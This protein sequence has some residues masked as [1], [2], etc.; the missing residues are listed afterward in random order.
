MIN[1]LLPAELSFVSA[2][3]VRGTWNAPNWN[4]GTM[5]SGQVFNI[6][7]TAKVNEVSA[8]STVINTV[9]NTQDIAEAAVQLDDH[10]EP[11]NITNSSMEVTKTS[12]PATDGNY[13]TLGELIKYSII[14]KNTGDTVLNNITITD[15]KADAGSISPISVATLAVGA[16][17]TFT[18]THKITQANIDAGKVT[19]QATAKATLSN[20]FEISDIS[21]DPDDLSS[22]SDDPTITPIV[23]T[24]KLLLEKIADPADDG[25]YDSLGEIINYELYVKNTGNVTLNNIV[26]TDSN[27]N[28]GSITPA[29]LASLAQGASYIFTAKHTI[30]Q[31]DFNA[32][33]V[34]NIATVTGT[35]PANGTVVS[36]Q[37]DDPATLAPNDATVVSVPEVGRLVATK[38]DVTPAGTVLNTVGQVIIY[39]IF[40]Q[41]TGTITLTDLNIVDPNADTIILDSTTGEDTNQAD[42]R[43]DS[44]DPSE[45]ATFIATH[46]I[47]Q[48]D[49]DNGKVTNR[50]TASALDT[51]PASVTDIT[52]DPNNPNNDMDDPTVTP[53]VATPSLSI[54]KTVNDDSNV[55]N[56]QVLTYIYEVTNDGNITIDAISI[57]D[58]HNGTGTLS[59]PALQSTTGTDDDIT[60]NEIETL[61]PGETGIWTA[62]YTVTTADITNQTDITNTVTATG[63]PKINPLTNTTANATKS[64][65]I[66]PTD[67]I[68]SNITL[69]HNL[70]TDGPYTG[71]TFSW[72]AVPNDEITGLS[73]SSQSTTEIDDQLINTSGVDQT[74]QY[75]ITVSNPTG[76]IIDSYKYV[77]TVYSQIEV[78]EDD[79]IIVEC[80]AEIIEPEAPIVLDY[81][82]ISILP[83]K[84]S[85][86]TGDQSCEGTK[87]YTFEYTDCGGN[88][89]TYNYTYIIDRTTPPATVP[90]NGTSTVECSDDA[91][92]PTP[93]AGIKDI[94][95]TDITAVL[96]STV[97]D[98][99]TL[100]C[101]GTRTYNY[102]FTDCSGLVSNW[103]YVYTIDKT[104]VPVVPADAGSTIECLA[105][106]VQPATPT[107]T[108]QCGNDIIPV[109]TESTDPTC[110]GTKVYT[111]TY[112][113]CASNVSVYTYTYTIDLTTKPVVPANAGS[114][115]EC[116]AD[117]VQPAAPIVTDQCGNTL[118]PVITESTDPACEGTKVY[119]FTYT[120]C[121]SN[122]SVYTYTYTIDL[123]IKPVVPADT[124]S[125]VECIVDA[126]QPATPAVTDQCGNTLTPVIT[127]SADPTCEGTKVYTYTYTDCASNVSVYTYTYTIDLTTKPIVPADAGSTVECLADAV[128]PAT[129]TVTDQ[130]GNDIIPVITES[131]DPTCEGTKVYTFTYT[132]CAS[133]VSV[134]T[135]TYTIDLTTKP[136]VP[137]NAGSTVNDIS[138]AVQ[139][140]APT[141]IDNCGKTIV[142]VVT[143]SASPVCDGTKI[144]TFTYTDCAGNSDVYVYTY[145]ID[146]TSTLVISN[147]TRTV[148]SNLPVNYDLKTVTPL[149]NPTFQ[150]SV[151]DNPNV[152][153]ENNSSGT[154]LNDILI[155]KTGVVQTVKY[156]V[157]PFNNKG[158]EGPTFD[159]TVTVNPE[160]FV[161]IMPT[162]TI[163]SNI[164]L[165][166]DLNADVNVAGANFK[167]AAVNNPNISGATTTVSSNATITD[168]LINTTG[169][170]QTVIYKI[171]PESIK[172]C[173][174][175][176]YTYTVTVSPEAKLIVTKTTLAATDGAY[177]SLGEVINY[178]ITVENPNEVALNNLSVTDVN[179]DANS[180]SPLTVPAVAA[181]SSVVFT[182]SHTIT[183]A[184]LDAGFVD[185]SAIGTAFDPC[186]TIVTDSSDDPTTAAA[187]DATR[188]II[189]QKP[190][191]AL[192][193]TFQFN[194]E[195]GDGIT[196]LNETVTYRF[197]VANTGNVNLT[198]IQITDP[199]ITVNGGPINLAPAVTDATTFFGTYTL[200]QGV[201]DAG[202]LTNSAIVTAVDPKGNEI[203]DISDDPKD[204]T[205]ADTNGNGNPDDSTIFTIVS[206]PELTLKKS[207]VFIDANSDGLAQAGEKIEYTFD[208]TNTGNVTTSGITISDLLTAVIGGPIKLIPGQT[209]SSTFTA[210]YTLSQ[211]DVNNG[212][213]VNTATASGKAPDGS[214]ITDASDD[215]S[216]IADNDATV[217]KLTQDAQL[218]LLKTSVFKDENGNGFPEVGE[219]IDYIFN[220]KNNGN[221]T[222]NDIKITDPLIT[223][224]GGPITLLPNKSDLATFKGSYT[225]T[226]NDINLG[227]VVNS[228][229]ATAK[230][231]SGD[232][233]TA[234][235]D[236][237]TNPSNVDTNGDGHPDDK[238]VTKLKAN[239]KLS[240]SKTG[241]F[242]DRNADGIAQVGE[243]IT[244]TFDVKNIGN[245]T[246]SN[247][248]ITD[249]LV[250]V[251]GGPIT[252]NPTQ[253]DTTTFT[254]SYTIKQSDIDA[255]KVTNTA[256]ASG[257]SPNGA[258]VKD[259]SDDP[260]NGTNQDI[261]GNGEPDD[262][263]VTP[264]PGKGII[265]LIKVALAPA[266]GAYDTVGEA[267]N[268]KLTVTNTGNLTL[269]NVIVTDTNAD[270]GSILPAV[271]ATIAP[272]ASAVVNANH[273]LTLADINS[274]GVTNSASVTSKDP[275]GN[276]ITDISDDPNNTND[277]DAN[278]DGDPDD[279]TVTLVTQKP[280][281]SLE[282]TA[283]F[284]DENNDGLP[285]L[286]ETITYNFKVSNTGNVSLSNVIV[287]DPLVTVSGG[288]ISLLPGQNNSTTFFANYTITQA[289]ID[290][291]SIVNAAT[292][293]AKD[294]KGNTVSD[295]SDDPTNATNNDIN[296]DGEPDDTTVTPLATKPQ[297]TITK[298][299]I[300]IDANSDGLAQA[301]ETIRYQFDVSNSGN[302]TVSGITVT[303]AR[304]TVTG[305]PITLL[306]QARNTTTF[307]AAYVLTQEDVDLGYV[308]NTATASGKDPMGN[309]V[310]D[311]SDDPTTSA[312]NDDTTTTLARESQLS[313]FKTATFNDENG[314]GLPQANETINYK[315]DI[316]NNGNVTV[317]N[318]TITDPIVPVVGGPIDLSP[319][320]IDDT[321]FTAIYTIKQSDIDSG[322]ISNSA[323]AA[324]QDR[325]GTVVTDVSDFSDDPDNPNDIDLNGDGDP[326]DPTVSSLTGKA[327]LSL[328]KTATFNDLNANGFADLNETIS[329]VFEVTNT[330]NLSIN[331]IL[332][333]DPLVTVT[334]NAID[335]APSQKDAT[336]FT[337]LYIIKQ[338]DLDAGQITNSA[339][340][341]GQDPNGNTVRDTSDD[342]ENAA[343]LD[344]NNDGNPDDATVTTFPVQGKINI[345]KTA[346]V[347]ADGPYDTVG[348]KITYNMV[349]TNTGSTTLTAVRVTDANADSGSIVPQ[350]TTALAPGQS[351]T[352]LATHTITQTDL[353]AGLVNNSAT[354][355]SRDKLGNTVLDIS[356]DPTNPTNI[357]ANADG[358]P[359]DVTVTAM[360]QKPKL[361]LTKTV[362]TAPDGLWDEV[363]EVILYNL[364]LTNTGNVTLTNVAV[365]DPNADNASVLPANFAKL[366]PGQ[367]VFL[368]ALHTITQ[369]D[370]DAASVTNSATANATDPK[371][372][373]VSDLSDDPN[374][375]ANVDTNGNGNP[376]DATVTA[377]PQTATMDLTKVTTT[378][379]FTNLG[380]ILTYTITVKNTG[381]VTLLNVVIQDANAT[382]TSSAT[383]STLSPGA[384]FA[385]TA[386]HIVTAEDLIMGFV[387]NSAIATAMIPSSNVAVS[388]DSDDTNDS[389]N[390]DIDGDGDF[391]D[392]TSS[393]L[394]TDADG[395]ADIIDIDDDND[396]ILDTV[397]GI[398]DSDGDGFVDS[399]DIDADNDGIPD[400]VEGQSTEAYIA[401]TGIDA[402]LNG[403]DDAYEK[404][405]TIG[406]TPENTD[407]TDLPDYL[408]DDSDNDGI[409]D[410]IEAFDKNHDGIP[411]LF[412]SGNDA[413]H[414]GLNDSFEGS[415]TT[416]GFVVNNGLRNGSLDTNNT[417]LTDQPDYRDTD[418]DNDGV[419]TIYE[420]DPNRDGNGPDDTDNDGIPDYLDTDDDGDGITTRREG[421][422]PNG[423]GNP[424]DAIDANANGIPDYLEVGNFN[425]NIPDDEIEVFNFVSSNS[426]GK[427][428]VLVLGRIFEFPENTVEIYNRWGVLVYETKGYGTRNNYFRGYSEG[429]VTIS[430]DDKLP[431]GTYFYVIKYRSGI[432]LKR[433]AGYLFLQQQ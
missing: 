334:G 408:D 230:D 358:D 398:N 56:A 370:L 389:T 400:N 380:D 271:I 3:A 379:R 206:K 405:T 235:S 284:N 270:N 341:S 11:I 89:A 323:I 164:P 43:V 303:D 19:N 26:I 417:D 208:V 202:S 354:V 193:K 167:W 12:L 127:A 47:T 414:D 166:H 320:Q 189:V 129:P 362:T 24:G 169:V 121:A 295:T 7:I 91:T 368:T 383:K 104:T 37:S 174:G 253:N 288:P 429:R 226:L 136:V 220:V 62:T 420:L 78:P 74:V 313:L 331:N 79:E 292:V 94:C 115:V 60:D 191:I 133:N 111:F 242:N 4:V 297:L 259:T 324:G 376:D 399:L 170:V 403:L 58:I 20:G 192:E 146:V 268:Y 410:T 307:K 308:I 134:Y 162:A 262:A 314:N 61:A 32:G 252:L 103:K 260:N 298:T 281:L 181:F 72:L 42:N 81:Q 222:L 44:I 386:Q 328:T 172:G 152:T 401:P 149:V 1:D 424:S 315:F 80:A 231:P 394:D 337:A 387:D 176:E 108:D 200:T 141:V 238:T 214:T 116:L 184:D 155:N 306:P 82:G 329:Y 280:S 53:L 274:G 431:S 33:R 135:Y 71:A 139:P 8:S 316:R 131:T 366:E 342:P 161:A 339:N 144:Y 322:S 158:C 183:Q 54:T 35:I 65:T 83:V 147:K 369:N 294:P 70:I 227:T 109:I 325:D 130:C 293:N 151:I 100:T 163:C 423:D 124:G 67:A 143:E 41:S 205:N 29:T 122:V 317:F 336:T 425:P 421:A 221:V 48:I 118:T 413:D 88:V 360:V 178:Q 223:I 179:A 27:A 125:S 361:A 148:C 289:N 197:K 416:D 296:G 312:K 177:D 406:I 45:T 388:E 16:S 21:D 207:G 225:L 249:A 92:P 267:I 332:I 349:V 145:Q 102:T 13:D 5:T 237:P 246:V 128:Q 299:G 373:A 204:N 243:Q 218:T 276:T 286:N 51:T 194:D 154:L 138:K 340:V 113:D 352:V 233:V 283:T 15:P 350:I 39:K 123:T 23:Q 353:N 430:K 261:N 236:D 343:N 359:D 31:G 381:T 185:N 142:P 217:T 279:A 153:G 391:E 34:S 84:T 275:F 385:T 150:W 411:D 278:A 216:T 168:T 404:G 318:V 255:G 409:T 190:V 367:K 224:S 285:Q 265:S 374:N 232:A 365:V 384:S 432:N 346:L 157:T 210:I 175:A 319:A 335:L 40:V 305:G 107:V 73:T 427:N 372:N 321:T 59:T 357:D 46:I 98:P 87:T 182:A 64:V 77:V 105:G 407:G 418:D 201:I 344:N 75:N 203:S 55:A 110:E 250:I 57:S 302:V 415:N 422:D 180:I 287:T 18:A 49:L 272:G 310:S 241:I 266:D 229:T 245:V 117:T 396:G 327:S 264:L 173:T 355:S 38:E 66:H 300:F 397:E 25:L 101:E 412:L 395:V 2:T 188:T 282:K 96:V 333:T 93:P 240:V 17:A 212:P 311:K 392:P 348:E 382:F 251:S 209:N 199:L 106:A 301:G 393:Y 28:T 364:T 156:T 63:K 52:D 426:D 256:I 351:T 119:T 85:T 258:I 347:A 239:P 95:G 428:D 68:C 132:N 195:N 273:T 402:N 120:D 211:A 14:V 99:S 9:S 356:D 22:N 215:P 378:P 187:N 363:G 247:I 263:T 171:T 330:G 126:V 277:D 254:A 198:G 228:A 234:L 86:A 137:A 6:F 377:I 97:D 165:N 248:T 290:A 69:S 304:V 326:D 30:V 213:V 10:T 186:D 219:T 309:T 345:T 90:A 114:T 140:T 338:A 269:T 112:T 244:Y 291:G 36:D 159:I 390:I 196:Q 50:A 375:P 257:V 433:K 419:F 160:P 371:G 76:T